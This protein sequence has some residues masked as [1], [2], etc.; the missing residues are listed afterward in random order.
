MDSNRTAYHPIFLFFGI[1]IYTLISTLTYI[2]IPKSIFFSAGMSFF[3]VNF[4]NSYKDIKKEFKDQGI[5]IGFPLTL[6]TLLFS[7]LNIV[8]WPGHIVFYILNKIFKN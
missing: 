6:L 8:I 1:V 7:S 4:I 5:A 2:L 3:V